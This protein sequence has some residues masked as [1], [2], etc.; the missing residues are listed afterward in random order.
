[1]IHQICNCCGINRRDFL[2]LSSLFTASAGLSLAMNGCTNPQST[3]SNTTNTTGAELNQPVK[4]G[5]LPI[6][7]ASPLLIA[8][9]RGEY[10]AQG[11]TT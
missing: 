6:L 9:A 1:M 4:I 8:H 2:K 10:E 11:L 5:Y 7:D 3:S